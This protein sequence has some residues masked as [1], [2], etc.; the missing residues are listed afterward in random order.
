MFLIFPAFANTVE[1][2][3]LLGDILLRFPD[4][5]HDILKKNKEWDISLKWAISFVGETD[6]LSEND[7]QL[8]HLV[9]TGSL[10]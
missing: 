3:M 4:I 1:N 6:I 8:M 7:S 9:S 2:T 10:P 5:T